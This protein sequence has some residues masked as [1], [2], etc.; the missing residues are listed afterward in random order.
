MRDRLSAQSTLAQF[1]HYRLQQAQLGSLAEPAKT[2]LQRDLNRERKRLV[3]EQVARTLLK[4]L[5]AVDTAHE[6]MVWFWFNHFNVFWQKGLVGAAL[7][8]YVQRAIELHVKGRFADMVLATLKHPAMLSYLDNAINVA[9]KL[10]ENYARELMELHTLGVQGGYSQDDVKVVAE[11]LAGCGI[12][13][14][15]GAKLPERWRNAAV[16]E[17][18]FFFDPR[19][20]DFASRRPLGVTIQV[21]GFAAVKALVELLSTHDATA[22]HVVG[23]LSVYLLGDNPPA[24]AVREA[25]QV[26]TSS[27]GDLA[28]T[29]ESL[30]RHAAL[31]QG[32][33]TCFQTPY[34]YVMSALR[35]LGAGTRYKEV[36]PVSRW[37]S[38]LGQ[39]LFGRRT[40]DGYS[41]LGQEWLSAGQITQRFDLA[42]EMVETVP[43]LLEGPVN[44]RRMLEGEPARTLL[45]RVGAV[46]RASLEKAGD[47]A[48][49]VALLLSSPE[50]MYV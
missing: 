12:R 19:R 20:H 32:R 47:D 16:E 38:G 18:A 6:E 24:A 10:N 25:E 31:G 13:P 43:R 26:F 49:R 35:L 7:G 48:T 3:D 50:F 9:G 14:V 40:P 5:N 11:M 17:E 27:R 37:L 33:G 44:A 22:R 45:A 8:D 21:Q 34:R 39:P 29:T 28:K 15:Q 30:R 4:T 36:Q 42:R 23:K 41:L 1:N 46:T 2:E